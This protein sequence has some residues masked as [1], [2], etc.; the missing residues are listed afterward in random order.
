ML[1]PPAGVRS[2]GTRVKAEIGRTFGREFPI[3]PWKHYCRHNRRVQTTKTVENELHL[4]LLLFNLLFSIWTKCIP[5]S[6]RSH[7]QGGVGN[8]NAR[9]KIM[10]K[11]SDTFLFNFKN[12][13]SCKCHTPR[14]APLHVSVLSTPPVLLTH[15]VS[16]GTA[17]MATTA[18]Q[19]ATMLTA[20]SFAMRP[21]R[22]KESG[23]QTSEQAGG[24]PAADY[25]LLLLLLLPLLPLQQPSPPPLCL[26][27]GSIYLSPLLFFSRSLHSWLTSRSVSS[28]APYQT[29]VA[30]ASVR[31]SQIMETVA[32]KLLRT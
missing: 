30:M 24:A 23:G 10:L 28:S 31:A 9:K 16:L 13:S 4:L 7:R 6:S 21:Y 3:T 20:P 8:L 27:L 22:Q 1:G 14:R 2:L 12:N 17:T 11:S 25:R 26:Q 15:P 29:D 19:S 5:L 32:S 18:C